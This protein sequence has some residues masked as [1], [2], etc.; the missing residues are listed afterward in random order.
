MPDVV[1]FFLPE[2]GLDGK[3]VQV[4]EPDSKWEKTVP[5]VKDPKAV[6]SHLHSKTHYK[7]VHGVLMDES[8][9]DLS[10]LEN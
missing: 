6:R 10:D 4:I 1:T 2:P 8:K 3:H 9:I 5:I 7:S